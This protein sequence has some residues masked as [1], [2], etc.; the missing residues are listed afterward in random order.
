MES[1]A[2]DDT[3][4]AASGADTLTDEIAALIDGR[5]ANGDIVQAAW[6]V[7]EI[8]LKHTDISGGDTDWYRTQTRRQV[9]SRV[10]AV[11]SRYKPADTTDPQL[12]LP[13]FERVQKAYPVMRGDEHVIV[14]TPRMTD[15]EIDEKIAELR[16]MSDGCRLHAN[17]LHR[18]KLDRQRRRTASV[19]GQPGPQAAA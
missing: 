12:V 8:M 1:A 14:E 9:A 5:L 13:G 3:P 4:R 10:R 6:I 16:R 18:Y 17:E 2:N 11:V 19:K 15:E 7:Q